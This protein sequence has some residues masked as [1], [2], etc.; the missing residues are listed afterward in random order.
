MAKAPWKNDRKKDK[1]KPKGSH[2]LPSISSSAY[3]AIL[4]MP[5]GSKLVNEQP[6][7][8]KGWGGDLERA[9]L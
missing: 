8:S 6:E 4:C 5:H 3:S 1:A 9:P 2:A 7:T